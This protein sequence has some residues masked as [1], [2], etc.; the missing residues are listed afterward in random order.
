ML[1]QASTPEGSLP[2]LCFLSD[3]RHILTA[4]PLLWA[5]KISTWNEFIS[6]S[7]RPIRMT[8]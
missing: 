7:P 3:P 1:F 8:Y 5:G 2:A 4:F 6:S